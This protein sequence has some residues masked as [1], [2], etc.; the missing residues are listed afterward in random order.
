[1]TSA[2]Q[3]VFCE[4]WHST[5]HEPVGELSEAQA[6]RRD[7]AGEPYLVVLGDKNRPDSLVEV[8]WSQEYLGTWFFDDKL[9]RYVSYAFRRISG[10]TLFLEQIMMWEYPDDAEDDLYTA[11][12]VT[13]FAYQEDGIAHEIIADSAADTEETISR[14]DVPLDINWEPVPEFGDWTRVSRWDRQS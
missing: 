6:R 10:T 2:A 9:R 12:K 7:S 5:R 13:T 1:V 4:R 14:S 3:V 8:N 11:S